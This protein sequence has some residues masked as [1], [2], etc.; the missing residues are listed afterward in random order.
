MSTLLNR[1]QKPPF[2][3][4]SFFMPSPYSLVLTELDNK[5]SVKAVMTTQAAPWGLSTRD[6]SLSI[7]LI[8]S[9]ALALALATYGPWR[10]LWTEQKAPRAPSV[11]TCIIP[12]PL[13]QHNYLNFSVTLRCEFKSWK[14]AM[15]LQQN[16]VYEEEKQAKLLSLR[17]MLQSP[18][19]QAKQ[20]PLTRRFVRCLNW[21][22]SFNTPDRGW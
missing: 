15:I 10:G 18:N 7:I 17:W 16:T 19:Y 11:L 3:R 22:D 5:W 4:S 2:N 14:A 1:P 21:P 8:L 9:L 6:Q 13:S 12:P 20:E